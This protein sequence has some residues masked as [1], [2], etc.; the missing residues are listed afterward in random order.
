[1]ISEQW[2]EIEEN[3]RM[4]K[5]RNLFKNIRDT[6]GT[7]HAKMGK[8]KDGNGHSIQYIHSI[9][10]W[11]FLGFQMKGCGYEK[12]AQVLTPGFLA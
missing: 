8:I 9:S 6:K 1:M 10:F 12:S 2:K 4:E 11:I 7:F 3:N 5:T